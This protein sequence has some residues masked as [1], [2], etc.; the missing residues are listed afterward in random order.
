[1]KEID[2]LRCN[3]VKGGYIFSPN[4]VVTKKIVPSLAPKWGY[5]AVLLLDVM[6]CD[7]I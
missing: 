3:L 5:T 4:E 6:W 2:V 1:M 7:S